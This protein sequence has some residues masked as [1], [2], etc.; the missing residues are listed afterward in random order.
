MSLGGNCCQSGPHCQPPAKSESAEAFK[1]FRFDV[2]IVL[3]GGTA[4]PFDE[5]VLCLTRRA[6]NSLKLSQGCIQSQQDA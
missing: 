1:F 2:F 4:W 5:H 6:K 3:G